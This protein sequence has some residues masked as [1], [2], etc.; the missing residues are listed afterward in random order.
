MKRYLAIVLL[1]V[2][3]G[4]QSLQERHLEDFLRDNPEA[5]FISVNTEFDSCWTVDG[6]SDTYISLV[7]NLTRQEVYTLA[8]ECMNLGKAKKD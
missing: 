8:E 6:E 1:T 2:G 3:C 5:R 7:S 4:A